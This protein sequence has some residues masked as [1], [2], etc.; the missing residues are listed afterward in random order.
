[1][2]PLAIQQLPIPIEAGEASNGGSAHSTTNSGVDFN[3]LMASVRNADKERRA[4][5][6][7][8]AEKL[9]VAHKRKSVQDREAEQE[10][11]ALTAAADFASRTVRLKQ[12]TADDEKGQAHAL[13]QSVEENQ[14]RP[15]H[16]S[17]VKDGED[18]ATL[19]AIAEPLS[20]N[21]EPSITT[22]RQVD[23][24]AL[25]SEKSANTHDAVL[26]APEVSLRAKSA[27]TN[28]KANKV[29]AQGQAN[30]AQNQPLPSPQIA[31]VET[32]TT[33]E[34][35]VG[36]PEQYNLAFGVQ[37]Q[38]AS[39]YNAEKNTLVKDPSNNNL[40]VDLQSLP[41]PA[42]ERA[43]NIDPKLSSVEA[44]EIEVLEPISEMGKID[45]NDAPVP[46]GT[47][48]AAQKVGDSTSQAVELVG[49]QSLNATNITNDRPVTPVEAD[50]VFSPMRAQT[51]DQ[52]TGPYRQSTVNELKAHPDQ[53]IEQSIL[54]P[55]KDFEPAENLKGS[56]ASYDGRS[57][58][59][60]KTYT[61]TSIE[62]TSELT[63]A[64]DDNEP[65]VP[66]GSL[67]VRQS[68]D[69]GIRLAMQAKPKFGVDQSVENVAPSKESV[70]LQELSKL[71][72][73]EIAYT[74]EPKPGQN[75]SPPDAS[76]PAPVPAPTIATQ[77]QAFTTTASTTTTEANNQGRTIAADIR[78]RALERMV[79]TAARAGT[80]TL[81]LQLYPP[82]LGQIM[83][84][85]VMDGQRLRIVTR[86]ANTEAVNTLKDMEG[87]LR[88]AL[89]GNG[90]D[91][92]AFDVTDDPQDEEQGRRRKSA[93]PSNT[94]NGGRKSESFTVDL[95]A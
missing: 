95:N 91:L 12:R 39:V 66:N 21:K 47:S 58:T 26:T 54:L 60:T 37:S 14:A 57:I 13:A 86:A 8:A 85:L 49:L 19:E 35:D 56:A 94:D 75:N 43:S 15:A 61:S 87:D 53:P 4:R 50:P 92:A 18:D 77:T 7:D 65:L 80:E 46:M 28:D 25:K 62:S 36:R 3:D 78:L 79:V 10:V 20:S 27:N 32:E 90:I 41:I 81:T 73:K 29:F 30:E 6:E 82:G 67:F 17:T 42:I 83:I 64:P 16:S 74:I 70:G 52:F 69:Q 51:T 40:S 63:A 5:A 68:A 44:S 72:V 23:P 1:M 2:Q 33:T 48:D 93:G 55:R 71:G 38:D 11:A 76:Q 88:N 9:S 24:A 84:R 89:S 31:G 22:P 45:T 59:A 34:E